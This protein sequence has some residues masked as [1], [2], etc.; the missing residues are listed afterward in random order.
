MALPF[1]VIVSLARSGGWGMGAIGPALITMT[2]GVVVG[3]PSAITLALQLTGRPHVTA[4]VVF[5][6]PLL[7]LFAGLNVVV[8][9]LVWSPHP[10]IIVPVEAMAA[11][12]IAR[13]LAVAWSRQAH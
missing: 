7:A 6:I 1:Y 5:V 11:G 9:R 12:I 13:A 10:A 8:D 3:V 4:T 2:L